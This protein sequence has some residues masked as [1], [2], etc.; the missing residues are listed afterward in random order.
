[1]QKREDMGIDALLAG[2]WSIHCRFY[3]QSDITI[4]VWYHIRDYWSLFN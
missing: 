3:R 2:D 4:P 1:M